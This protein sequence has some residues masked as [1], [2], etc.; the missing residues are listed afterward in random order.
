MAGFRITLREAEAE[1]LRANGD[2]GNEGLRG[3][4]RGRRQCEATTRAGTR[5]KAPAIPGGSVCRRHGG[6]A[7]QVQVRAA[8]MALYE[9]RKAWEAA[10]GTPGEFDA[11]CAL[12]RAENRVTEAEAKLGQL[13]ELCTEL[14][15]RERDNAE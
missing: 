5:C 6:S 4:R 8:M 13:R 11:L 10:R 9:A 12:S 15:R 2:R 3:L 7:K 1:R 14:R